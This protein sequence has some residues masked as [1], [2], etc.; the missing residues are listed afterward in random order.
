MKKQLLTALLAFTPFFIAAK[1]TNAEL[2]IHL[3]TVKADM[4]QALQDVDYYEKE[5]KQE[6]GNDYILIRKTWDDIHAFNRKL[7]KKDKKNNKETES[8]IYL[9]LMFDLICNE[10]KSLKDISDMNETANTLMFILPL[11]QEDTN[12]HQ[13]ELIEKELEAIIN[14]HFKDVTAADF[15]NDGDA[16]AVL[17]II[18]GKQYLTELLKKVNAKIKELQKA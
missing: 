2:L 4:Q 9:N 18:D 1:P 12:P 17:A 8:L 3:K 16:W 10:I 5:L 15:F 6:W 13:T 7:E 11:L 14:K